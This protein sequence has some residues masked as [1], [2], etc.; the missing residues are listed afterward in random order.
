MEQ[1]EPDT[2]GQPG[3]AGNEA[4]IRSGSLAP[5]PTAAELKALVMPL[6]R[7]L[8]RHHLSSH[9]MIVANVLVELSYGRGMPSV[10]LPKLDTLSDLTGIDRPHVHTALR[11]MH[12]MRILILRQKQG[13]WVYRITPNSEG[14]KVKPRIPVATIQRA[15]DVVISYNQAIIEAAAEQGAA[16]NFR[17]FPNNQIPL[18]PC[19]DSVLSEGTDPFDGLL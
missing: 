18:F 2:P 1:E 19:T 11:S 4:S 5:A 9:E 15:M 3:A 13:I 14:W 17:D 10:R 8:R 12:E 16:A 6:Q 7:E